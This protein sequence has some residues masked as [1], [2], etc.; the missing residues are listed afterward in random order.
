MPAQ[1]SPQ[2]AAQ[3]PGGTIGSAAADL[4]DAQADQARAYVVNQAIAAAQP[5]PGIYVLADEASIGGR[6]HDEGTPVKIQK[7]RSS[8]HLYAKVWNHAARTFDYSPGTMRQAM[9]PMTLAEA[10]AFGKMYG[11]C[12][13]CGRELTDPTSVARAM[14]PVCVKHFAQ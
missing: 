13:R 2:V 10:E 8:G 12:V 3:I 1:F 14:G 6:L 4:E 5:K 9:R 7:S 11:V